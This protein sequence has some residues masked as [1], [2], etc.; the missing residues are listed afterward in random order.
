MG[1]LLRVLCVKGS[2]LKKDGSSNTIINLA[3]FFRRRTKTNWI[4][5]EKCSRFSKA[6][7]L[8]VRINVFREDRLKKNFSLHLFWTLIGNSIDSGENFSA[9]LSKLHATYPAVQVWELFW[10]KIEKYLICCNFSSKR[11]PEGLSKLLFTKSQEHLGRK[12]FFH[13]QQ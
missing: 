9:L 10:D 13:W 3:I 11:F 7:I 6:G 2:N 8:R 1:N 12:L 4:F 5:P